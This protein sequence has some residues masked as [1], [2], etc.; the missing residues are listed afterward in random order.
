[1]VSNIVRDPVCGM[2]FPQ[3]RAAATY[4]HEG[5]TYYFCSENCKEV[6]IS[7]IDDYLSDGG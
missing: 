1:M 3:E 2:E 5:V 7:H 6:F 4:E